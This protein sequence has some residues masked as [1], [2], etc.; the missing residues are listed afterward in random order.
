MCCYRVLVNLWSKPWIYALWRW[1]YF[2]WL[3][4]LSLPSELVSG[5]HFASIKIMD[6]KFGTFPMCETKALSVLFAQNL[7][8]CHKMPAIF[9]FTFKLSTSGCIV[10]NRV[11]NWQPQPK[12]VTQETHETTKHWQIRMHFCNFKFNIVLLL[13][14]FIS[15]EKCPWILPKCEFL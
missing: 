15:L 8:T 13:L 2:N 6:N 4:C 12:K 5:P 14:L 7:P 10:Q 9:L 3:L 11:Q 1:S